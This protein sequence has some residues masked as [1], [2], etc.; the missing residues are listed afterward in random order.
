MSRCAAE[1]RGLGLLT[2]AV[3]ALAACSGPGI[4]PGSSRLPAATATLHWARLTLPRGSY[5]WKTGSSGACADAAATDA[6]LKTGYL[7]PYRTAGGYRVQIAYDSQSP[8]GSTRID[9]IT[10]PTGRGGEVR[11]SAPLAFDLPVIPAEGPG[12]YVYSITGTWKEGDVSFLLA[13]DEIPGG[14]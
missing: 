6:L 1:W 9:L 2:V 3:C 11:Q 5:C 4:G 7:K 13:L 10:A 12:I 8:P 14:A